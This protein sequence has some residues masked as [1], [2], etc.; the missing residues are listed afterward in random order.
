MNPSQSLS[1]YRAGGER[2]LAALEA[3][4]GAAAHDP[5]GVAMQY[6]AIALADAEVGDFAAAHQ[7][8]QKAFALGEGVEPRARAMALV[9]L[10]L[11]T[12]LGGDPQGGRAAALQAMAFAQQ[13]DLNGEEAQALHHLAVAEAALGDV[14]SAIEH[15]ERALAIMAVL[16]SQESGGLRSY[17]PL[18]ADL[19]FWYARADDLILAQERVAQ[20]LGNADLLE[21]VFRSQAAYCW[22][23]AAQT[24]RACGERDLAGK[25]L[26]RSAEILTHT[27]VNLEE[28][29]RRRYLA[30]PWRRQVH[31]AIKRSAWPRLNM[32]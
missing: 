1:H 17:P 2:I 5:T 11:F 15:G 10:S 6:I 26:A 4:G 24:L 31:E 30:V 7:K 16:L 32:R 18:L 14:T 23:E 29:D 12:T 22:W 20:V 19:A 25:A 28:T 13:N 8:A 21:R 27:A 9:N 3:S